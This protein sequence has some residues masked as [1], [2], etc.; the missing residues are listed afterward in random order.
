MS[1][2][3]STVVRRQL[4]RRLRKL[5]EAARKS[6]RDVEEA[7]LASRAKLWRIESG[8]SPVKVAD[9]RALCWL[10]GADVPTTDALTGLCAGTTTQGWWEDYG[11]VVPDWFGLYV[12]LEAGATEIL[13]YDPELVHGLLQTPD[14]TRAVFLA[15]TGGSD[16][17]A[18]GHQIKVRY[19]RQQALLHRQPPLR[20]TAVLGA[21]VLA[22]PVGGAATMAEQVARLHELAALDHVEIRILPW[23]I[24]AHPAMHV[25]PFTILD[26]DDADDPAVVYLE[27]HTGARYLERPE[28]LREYHRIFDLIRRQS[29][30]IEEHGP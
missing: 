18:V 27:S 11:D 2:P 8:K 14:Y 15:V 3:G 16:Q 9:V 22:R 28:E 4:G 21:G 13:I 24:G 1:V 29:V 30:P 23:A 25:G 10:Y 17:E 26:F 6:E 7:R 5:R 20:L 19:E 12:G